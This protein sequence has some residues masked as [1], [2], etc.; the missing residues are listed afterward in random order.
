MRD[1]L[2]KCLECDKQEIVRADNHMKN[3]RRCRI[4]KGEL[5]PVGYLGIESVNGANKNSTPYPHRVKKSKSS[6]L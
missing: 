4:C 1:L 2:Y 5:E 3:G 6:S